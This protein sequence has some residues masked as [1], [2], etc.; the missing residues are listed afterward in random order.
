MNN[1]VE[2]VAEIIDPEAFHAVKYQ[3]TA[4]SEDSIDLDDKKLQYRRAVALSK[5]INI[6]QCIIGYRTEKLKKEMID[7][8]I[9]RWK[10]VF[11]KKGIE[12]ER[13]EKLMESFIQ[14]VEKKYE[15]IA[16]DI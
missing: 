11:R 8:E 2:R 5:S 13:L 7:D 10:T 3:R 6:L 1:I 9:E 16:E 14:G 4:I 12:E 15:D